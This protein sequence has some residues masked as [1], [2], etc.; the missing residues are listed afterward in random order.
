MAY[1]HCDPE[2]AFRILRKVSNDRNIKLRVVAAEVARAV[3][4]GEPVPSW[5]LPADGV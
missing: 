1:R 5:A 3:S 2:R 4:A